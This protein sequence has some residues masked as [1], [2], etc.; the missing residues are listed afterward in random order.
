MMNHRLFLA[1]AIAAS[2]LAVAGCKKDAGN[3]REIELPEGQIHLGAQWAD[4]ELWI[5]TLDPKTATCTF[6][7]YKD[8][9]AVEAT[10]I[11]LKNCKAGMPMPMMRPTMPPGMQGGRPGMM[12]RPGMPPRNMP[13]HQEAPAVQGEAPAASQP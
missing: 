9:K 7:Q 13:P 6:S 1:A 4:G 3:T 2:A 8:G 11:T 12:Q 5:E 10:A